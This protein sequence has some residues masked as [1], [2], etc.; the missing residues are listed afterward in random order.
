[1]A[2]VL[3]KCTAIVLVHSIE[4]VANL[5]ENGSIDDFSI[6]SAHLNSNS[7]CAEYMNM[8]DKMNPLSANE[9]IIQFVN[10][11]LRILLLEYYH[12]FY[13]CITTRILAIICKGT[14]TFRHPI[15]DVRNPLTCNLQF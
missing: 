5:Q 8:L 15:L 1:M 2:S 14:K 13:H 4:V 9:S 12:D 3:M 10:P 6:L 11:Y 7:L